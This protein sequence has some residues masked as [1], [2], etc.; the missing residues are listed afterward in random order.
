[1]ICWYGH[2]LCVQ[3]IA[4]KLTLKT[5]KNAAKL[6]IRRNCKTKHYPH[7]G[8]WRYNFYALYSCF[9]LKTNWNLIQ[10]RHIKMFNNNKKIDLSIWARRTKWNFTDCNSFLYDMTRGHSFVF[11]HS[12]LHMLSIK[13]KCHKEKNLRF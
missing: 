7:T 12:T 2:Y 13:M 8:M 9:T 4:I 5:E 10:L 11:S 1:M 6:V 3:C